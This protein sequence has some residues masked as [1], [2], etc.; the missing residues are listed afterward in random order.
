MPFIIWTI[1]GLKWL[2]RVF[3]ALIAAPVWALVHQEWRGLTGEAMT[4]WMM[5]FSLLLM[6]S[7]MVT[8]CWRP[9]W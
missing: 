5:L 3:E 9:P 1:T 6:P 4:G 8:A 2:I 7:L